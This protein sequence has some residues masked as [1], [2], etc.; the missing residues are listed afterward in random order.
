MQVS[1]L[2]GVYGGTG[3]NFRAIYPTNLQPV[4]TDTGFSEGFLRSCPGV[5]YLETGPGADRGSILWQGVSYRVMGDRLVSYDASGTLTDLGALPGG[6]DPV[7]MDFSFDRLAIGVGGGLYYYNSGE[8]ITQVTD[9]DLG[10]VIDMLWIDGYFMTTDGVHLV[11]TELDDPYSVDPLK[12]GSSE[13]DPD[14]IVAIAKVRDEVYAINTTTI[15]NFQNIG[16]TGFP[17]TRNPGGMISKGAVGTN[18]WAY[19]KETFAFVGCGRNEALS[20]YIAGNGE[21]LSIST[22]EIDQFLGQ[23]TTAQQIAIE[24]ESIVDRDEQRLLIHLPDKTLVY[25][26]A[27]SKANQAPVWHIQASGVNADQAYAARHFVRLN[28]AWI[29]GDPSGRLGFLSDG[30]ETQ[31]GD[32][33]GWMFNTTLLWNQGHGGI[34]K[35]VELFGLTGRGTESGDPT[36][37]LSLTQDGITYGQERAIAMGSLG[38]Y[39]KRM[40]WRPK[41]RFANYV[42]LK[43]RGTSAGIASFARLEVDVEP[44]YV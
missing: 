29:G 15:E 37:F 39:S 44:L 10:T 14:P 9:P 18:A 33:V 2:K 20:V 42:G 43:F 3:G 6:T 8:G 5:A 25:N 17:F 22:P 31:F 4:V 35:V 32:P 12:Y 40:Q 1:I 21:A 24:V 23:L 11:V 27:A 28:N 19:F 38:Q 34:I 36:M 26:Y 16:G 41:T 7:S 13:V 30:L